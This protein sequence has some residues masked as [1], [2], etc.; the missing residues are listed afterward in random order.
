MP[1]RMTMTVTTATVMM[2]TMMMTKKTTTMTI[3]MTK[4]LKIENP[5]ST[6]E[7]AEARKTGTIFTNGMMTIHSMKSRTM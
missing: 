2:T 7:T 4:D 6:M 3:V 5:K 1:V